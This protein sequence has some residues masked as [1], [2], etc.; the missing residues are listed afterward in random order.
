MAWDEARDRVVAM[1]DL[2]AAEAEHALDL[3]IWLGFLG[4]EA[5]GGEPRF[6]YQVGGDAKR[7]AFPVKSG[8]GV[9]AIHPAFRTSLGCV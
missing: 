3:L 4:V 1:L 5:F 2:D 8:D 9:V 6:S 7:L